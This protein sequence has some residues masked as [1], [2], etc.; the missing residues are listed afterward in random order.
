MSQEYQEEGE[1]DASK[2]MSKKFLSQNRRATMGR[3]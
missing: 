3:N 2:D 1:E